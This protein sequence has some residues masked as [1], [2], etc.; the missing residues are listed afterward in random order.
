MCTVG[1][2]HYGQTGG[3]EEQLSVV[4]LQYAAYV[5]EQVIHQAHPADLSFTTWE[6]DL[7][8]KKRGATALFSVWKLGGCHSE[9]GAIL[10]RGVVTTPGALTFSINSIDNGPKNKG[11]SGVSCVHGEQISCSAAGLIFMVLHCP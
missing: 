4:K 3:S 9:H 11:I 10:W 8:A 5:R 6:R 1:P 2:E 7:V